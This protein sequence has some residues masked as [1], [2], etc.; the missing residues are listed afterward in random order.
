MPLLSKPSSAARMSLMYITIGALILIWSC[1]WYVWLYMN[2]PPGS[3]PH[4]S[5]FICT[6]LVLT[7]LVLLVIGLALGRIGRAARHAELPPPEA[8]PTVAQT[9][10]IAA[11]KQPVL[12]ANAAA[13][14]P[15]NPG[16]PPVAAPVATPVVVAQ[17]V[18]A[19]RR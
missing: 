19:P 1:V 12:T 4:S 11:A 8:T 7:G 9:D 2:P 17:P 6:G 3:F 18:A 15:A 10:Q 13:V 16:A 14:P 5:Y